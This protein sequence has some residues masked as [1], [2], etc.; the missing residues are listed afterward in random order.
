MIFI[1]NLADAV[2]SL[3]MRSKASW[4]MFVP[5]GNT[6]LAYDFGKCCSAQK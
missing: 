1:E 2:S 5:L 3:V 6:A 4:N